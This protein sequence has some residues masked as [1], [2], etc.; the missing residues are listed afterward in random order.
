MLKDS[1]GRHHLGDRPMS[2]QAHPTLALR[3]YPAGGCAAAGRDLSRQHRGADRRGLQRGAARRLGRGRRRRGGL[4]R[5]GSARRSRSSPRSAARRSASSSLKGAEQLDMLYVHPA[6]PG[7][8]SAPCC[9]TRS[10]GSRPRAARRGS[11]PMPATARAASSSGAASSAQH[12]N[13]VLRGDEWLANTTME[14]KLRKRTP[15][16]SAS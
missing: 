6:W 1:Q 9:A 12:R 5:R 2:A 10:S 4:R 16:G 14:K 3:P 11:S 13:T 8:G 7:R 15:K